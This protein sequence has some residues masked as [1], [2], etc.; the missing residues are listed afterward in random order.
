M[1]LCQRA[2]YRRP[3]VELDESSDSISRI[4]R[5]TFLLRQDAVPDCTDQTLRIGAQVDV[6]GQSPPKVVW[7][8]DAACK[9][10][11]RFGCPKIGKAVASSRS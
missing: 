6:F 9:P 11:L 1:H 4:Q 7:L 5:I 8:S 10:L 2:P 3:K